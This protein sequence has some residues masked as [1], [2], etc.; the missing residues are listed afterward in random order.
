[1]TTEA[2]KIVVIAGLG[3]TLFGLFLMFIEKGG[4]SGWSNWFGSMPFDFK[5]ERENF[6]FYFPLGS[7]VLLSFL[8]SL[9]GYLVN[10]FIR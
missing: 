7:S 5:I 6:R 9:I 8:L 1:V 10:K 3:I 2:G 4:A